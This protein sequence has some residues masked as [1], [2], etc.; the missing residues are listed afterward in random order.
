[1][2]YTNFTRADGARRNIIRYS[3]QLDNAAIWLKT[4][5]DV[6]A[7][8]TTA[9]DGNSTAEL[10]ATTS[11]TADWYI[12]QQASLT[13]GTIYTASV[14]FKPSA[15]ATSAMSV[16]LH[17]TAF[18]VNIAAG[19]DRNQ[20][21]AVVVAG[22]PIAFGL[23]KLPNGWRRIW[24]SGTA[25]VTGFTN[26]AALYWARSGQIG[27]YSAPLDPLGEGYYL[28]GGQLEV[29]GLTA[30]QPVV[31]GLEFNT[32]PL[33]HARIVYENLAL[34]ITPTASSS[35]AGRPA[36]AATYPTTYEYWTPTTLPATWSVDLGSA[37]NVDSIGMVGDMLGCTVAIQYSTNNSTWVTVDT[38]TVVTDRINMF[39]FLS[40]SA[41]YWRVSVSVQIPRISVIY[42]GTALAM[43]R[44][45][46]QGHTP[47][48]LSRTTDLSNNVSEGGQYLGRSIIR[49]GA[50]SSAAWSN[51]RADWYRAN[52][53]PFVRAARTA[54]FFFG[55]RPA[56]Y[57]AELGFVWTDKDIAPDN[58]GPRN[59]MSVDVG[60]KGLINE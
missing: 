38:R 41:R 8:A 59:F 32:E 48:T 31:S 12:F 15:G 13:A 16:Y 7:N 43:Q 9:P 56:Q 5:C 14:Y 49:T 17:S 30:Y 1:M 26:Y 47:L 19:W 10:V 34:G 25:T 11:T 3:E 36:I 57:P 22:S 54:P 2:I 60:F 33:N 51:L 21:A 40:V 23:E 35:A 53:D 55:W 58:S 42:I 27:T 44:P 4:R 29:G 39:L 28:W 18:G 45:I 37:K 6:T 46:Y 20:D 52:F 24:V 50:E